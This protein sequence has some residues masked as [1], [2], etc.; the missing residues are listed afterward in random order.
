MTL[1]ANAVRD[2]GAVYEA[3]DSTTGTINVGDSAVTLHVLGPVL[4][5][6][7]PHGSVYRWFSSV[8]ETVNGNSVIC[9]LDIGTVRIILPGDLNDRSARHLLTLPSF[10]GA[11]DAHVFKAPHHGSHRFERDYLVAVNPQISVVSSG[12]T[13]DHGHPRANFL[14]TI[15]QTS[16]SDEP[17]LFST[18][19]VA[20]FE[21][22][23]DAAAPD[24]D[25]PVDPTDASMIS[26]ARRRFKKRLNGIIN[27]RT[28]GTN[29]YAARRVA[30]GYRFVTYGPISPSPRS[31]P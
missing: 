13:P 24:A 16:R 9:R 19:L 11:Q 17:L 18:E 28:D 14:G 2:S 29:L 10:A 31:L 27:V 25:D 20:L 3:V 23:D 21:V 5:N 1:W 12:E 8:G 6:I 30:A 7:S 15:G 26:Q 4:E 22:D